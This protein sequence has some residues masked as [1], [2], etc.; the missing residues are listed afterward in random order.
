MGALNLLEKK[1]DNLENEIEIA[2]EKVKRSSVLERRL[3]SRLSEME[4]KINNYQENYVEQHE[5]QSIKKELQ[6]RHKLDMNTQRSRVGAVLQQDQLELVK[7]IKESLLQKRMQK[8]QRIS[9]RHSSIYK[10]I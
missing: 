4:A 5:L 3:D 1:I 2:E 8:M 9:S 6:V 10:T 7:A